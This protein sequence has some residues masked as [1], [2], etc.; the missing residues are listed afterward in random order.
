MRGALEP[1]EGVTAVAVRPGQRAF[2]VLYDPGRVG[3]DAM[4]AAL[5]AAG[6]PARV[7]S[8]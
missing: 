8:P 3:V 2:S 1:L 7:A 4:L 5:E 6:E